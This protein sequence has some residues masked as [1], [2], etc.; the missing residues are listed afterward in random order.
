[1]RRLL[2]LLLATSTLYAQAAPPPASPPAAP[3][4]AAE[5]PK[6]GGTHSRQAQAKTDDP[7]TPL[8]EFPYTP[9]LDV[10]AM[11]RTADPCVD[12]YQFSCGG[13]MKNNPIPPDQARW[14]V[15]GKLANDNQRYL[16]GVLEDV[17]KPNAK[18]NAVQA[19]IG[20]YFAACMDEAAIN[21]LGVTPLK[22]DLDAIHGLT[23][24]DQLAGWLGKEHLTFQGNGMLFGF[25]SEQDAKNS[26]ET[27]ATATQGGLSLPDRDYY[28]KTDPKSVELRNK[29]VAHVTRMMQ[30]AGDPPEKAAAE[31][32]TI[33]ASRRRWP[34]PP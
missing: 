26:L 33:L 17:S 6:P 3:S 27:I 7:Q 2:P 32:T 29:Y 31:A 24:T 23:S 4:S 20:D 9:G 28:V 8:K 5:K 15:Y 34:R 11:D 1:M 14:S 30:L 19:Q 12:L 13:W 21:K 16:W 22:T 18:R 10:T 25:G